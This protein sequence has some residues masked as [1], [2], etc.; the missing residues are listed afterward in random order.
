MRHNNNNKNNKLYIYKLIIL[1]LYFL[2]VRIRIFIK[3]KY[4]CRICA[5]FRAGY[6]HNIIKC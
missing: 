4:P 2:V 1:L 6:T 5:S 3:I